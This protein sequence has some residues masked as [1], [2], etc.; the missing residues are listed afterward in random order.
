MTA[1]PPCPKCKSEFTYEDGGNFVCPEC[2]HEW[3]ASAVPADEEARVIKDCP[4]SIR[5]RGARQSR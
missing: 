5:M 1:L 2:A 3:T 4:A